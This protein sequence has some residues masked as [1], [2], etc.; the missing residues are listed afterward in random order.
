MNQS[1]TQNQAVP[2]PHLPETVCFTVDVEDYFMSPETISFEQWSQF[3]P[4]IEQGM[5]RCI[6]LLDEYQAKAT[7]FFLGWVAER[8]PALVQE[9]A[10]RGHE[11]GTHTYNH[12]F[13][14]NLQQP[15]FADSV[16]RS[17]DMLRSLAPDQQVT[18][19]R[20]PAFSLDRQKAWQFEVLQENGITYDSS[21]NPH[22]TYLYGEANAP[23]HPYW[24]HGLMEIPPG[25]INILGNTFPVG[26]GGT[27]RILPGWYQ[28]WARRRYLSEGYPPVIYM[29][30]WEFVPEHPRLPLPLKQRIIHWWGLGS[31]ER[32]VR[33]ILQEYQSIPMQEYARLLRKHSFSS[34]A[35]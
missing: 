3:E 7:F 9:T 26:G 30:P 16:Q 5:Q 33:H 15:Q 8:F 22:A 31:V 13:V 2:P 20:A 21:I 10:R 18:G 6:D 12:T 29:H 1:D 28:R 23:R 34:A 25:V 35:H 32:K 19:H 24:L 14:T 27:L 11:I 17:V 4:C